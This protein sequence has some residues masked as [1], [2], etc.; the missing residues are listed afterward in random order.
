[1]ITQRCNL[2]FLFETHIYACTH[3]MILFSSHTEE[4][5]SMVKLVCKLN[6]NIHKHTHTHIHTHPYVQVHGS[7][8]QLKF[9]LFFLSG[10]GTHLKSKF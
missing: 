5:E 1:V 7:S 8:P 4:S 9:I 10:E 2:L 6:S 3:S